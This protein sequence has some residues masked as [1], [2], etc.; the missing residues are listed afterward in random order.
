MRTDEP[1]ITFTDKDAERVHHHHDD[2]IVITL[3]IAD[4]T[5]KRVVAFQQMR[6]GR[7]QLRPVCSPLVGFGGMK[8]QPVGTITLPVVVGSYLQQITKEVN[9]L[10]VD[11]SSSYNGIIGRPTLN[12]LKAV[13]FTY[14]LLVK[15]PTEYGVGKVQGDQL[16]AREC[17]LAMLAMD[18]QVQTMSIEER[19]VVAEPTEVLEDI[20]LDENNPEKYT[21]V[22]ASMENKMKQNLIQFLKKSIDVFAWSHEDMPGID[23]SVITYHLNVHPS[24]KLVRQEKRVFALERDNSI[25][26]EV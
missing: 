22:R 5:T 4:Y 17:Y 21:R 14:H 11:C 2:A 18:E 9:F 23:P 3:L 24:S 1:A 10:V 15:F 19:R 12:N 16:V 8:V 6:F 26:E 20:P 7:D 13:T 25:K